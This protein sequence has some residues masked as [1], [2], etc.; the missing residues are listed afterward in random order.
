MIEEYI[1][2]IA[3][4]IAY[5]GVFMVVIG[6]LGSFLK[7]LY[8]I[9]TGHP[10]REFSELRHYLMLYLT[11][12]LD[13]LIAKD[14]IVTLSIEREGYTGLIQ[15]LIIVVIRIFLSYFIHMEETFL[16][17]FKSQRTPK[18]S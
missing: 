8:Y 4:W 7:F 15:L 5:I 13:F 1:R 11:V 2:I 18:K 14:I 17:K 6:A 9:P 10:E 3:T 12:G 16:H